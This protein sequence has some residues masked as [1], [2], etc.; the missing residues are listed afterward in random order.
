MYISA[1][2]EAAVERRPA[3]TAVVGGFR[4][5]LALAYISVKWTVLDIAARGAPAHFCFFSVARIVACESLAVFFFRF[6]E[7]RQS[8][9]LHTVFTV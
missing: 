8:E 4:A 1:V 3:C 9:A 7:S 6:S 2:S 5:A